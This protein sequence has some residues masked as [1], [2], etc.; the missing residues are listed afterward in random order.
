MPKTGIKYL[1]NCDQN[2]IFVYL[3]IFVFTLFLDYSLVYPTGLQIRSAVRNKL[4]FSG[5]PFFG[6]AKFW[7]FYSPEAQHFQK[8]Y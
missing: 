5:G 4:T 2:F 8:K 1:Q 3:F 7:S 6:Q